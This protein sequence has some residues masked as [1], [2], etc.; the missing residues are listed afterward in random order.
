MLDFKRLTLKDKDLFN[1][2]SKAYEFISSEYSFTNLY[3]WKDYYDIHYT[4]F[5]DVLIIRKKDSSGKYS[6]LQPLVVPDAGIRE[7]IEVLA[8]YSKEHPMEYIFSNVTEK[9]AYELLNYEKYNF[10]IYEDRDNFDYIYESQKL[11][12][13][14]GKNYHKKKNH[15]NSFMKNY[16]FEILNLKDIS[17]GDRV[18]DTTI[19]WYKNKET[20]D[21]AV[22]YE[23]QSIP[24]LLN[25]MDYLGLEGVAIEVGEKIVGFSIGEKI[26][27]KIAII[28]IEKGDTS[29]NG[30]YSFIN[31][32]F[33]DKCFND[34]EFINREQ[35]L[36]I[37]GLRKA[38]ESYHPL[39]LEK[40]FKVS[41]LS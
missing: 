26:N 14:P 36:G 4:L 37:Q 11:S 7:S 3:I 16:K 17:I 19:K 9:F 25:N 15:Y 30:I 35:D 10:K 6:F 1:K 40:K 18:M 12:K 13:L 27:D 24:S 20:M 29:Y 41:I 22:N 38:K 34:V 8:E 23:L 28:H 33:I 21:E 5:N 2:Y 31:K 32:I 39:F